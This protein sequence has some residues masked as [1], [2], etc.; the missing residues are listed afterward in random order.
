MTN[1]INFTTE[2][3]DEPSVTAINCS[4]CPARSLKCKDSSFIVISD[5]AKLRLLTFKKPE[6]DEVGQVTRT[7]HPKPLLSYLQSTM[8]PIIFTLYTQYLETSSHLFF[9]FEI[10]KL[11]PIFQLSG[12]YD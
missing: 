2:T 1:L 9:L 10:I 6:S 5:K 11:H 3:L 8:W 7:I 4:Y 12:V